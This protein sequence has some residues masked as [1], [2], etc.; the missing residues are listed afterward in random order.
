MFTGFF[1]ARRSLLPAS[2]APIAFTFNMRLDAGDP[3][4]RRGRSWAK[5]T[6][7][8]GQRADA[9]LSNAQCSFF[10]GDGVPR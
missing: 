10:G 7:P 3:C 1:T 4:G 2:L 5:R 8:D 6:G 9:A